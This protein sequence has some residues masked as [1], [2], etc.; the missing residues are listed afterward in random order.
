MRLILMLV[1]LMAVCA[2][3]CGVELMKITSPDIR[4]GDYISVRFTCQGLDISPRLEFVNIPERTR[5]FVLIVHDPDAP[6]G[7]WT[8]WLVFNIPANKLEIGEGEV[9]GI[10]GVNDFGRTRWG[11]P[12]PPQGTHRYFFELYALDVL[13]P[14]SEG[15]TRREVEA[16]MKEH[17]LG[18]ADLEGLYEK[19]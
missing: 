8:H 11:G 1:L 19:I 17:I 14:L 9:P 4:P 6:S 15:V 3:A 10:E 7:D 5:S 18:K 2:N 13:L 16:G 12:C